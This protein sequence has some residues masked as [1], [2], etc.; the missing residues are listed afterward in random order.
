M[1]SQ[2]LID[3]SV[4]IDHL[5]FRDHRLETLV[6][7]GQALCHPMVLGELTCGKL[8]DRSLLQWLREL[9]LA[10]IAGHDEV[11]GMVES[12]NLFGRGLGWI[13]VHVIASALL[14][15][16]RLYT[17]DKVLLSTASELGV[18]AS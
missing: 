1:N 13:D 9:K 5:N 16:N 14:S 17:H 12:L 4:W 6:E 8:Q 7:K 3:T 2:I 15:G 10:P 11:L 18:L